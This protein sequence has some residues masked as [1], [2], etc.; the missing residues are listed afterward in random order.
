MLK[1]CGALLEASGEQDAWEEGGGEL[2]SSN[3]E[4]APRIGWHPPGNVDQSAKLA[5]A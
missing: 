2:D 4:S 1:A 3:R 5:S